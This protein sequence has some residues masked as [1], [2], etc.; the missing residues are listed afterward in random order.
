MPSS[1]QVCLSVRVSRREAAVKIA[2]LTSFSTA[3]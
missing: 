3:G 1:V 2:L